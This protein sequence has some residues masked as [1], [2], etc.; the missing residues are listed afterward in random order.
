[1]SK[2]LNAMYF[3][4]FLDYEKSYSTRTLEDIGDQ[5]GVTKQRVWQIV[6]FGKLG[7]G[8]YY[9]GLDLYNNQ[10]KKFKVK[11]PELSKAELNGLMR[12]WLKTKRITL[13]KNGKNKLKK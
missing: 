5:W 7:G 1:M 3:R 6:R 9:K 2:E 4:I 10:L 12:D 8:D 13:I 11:H